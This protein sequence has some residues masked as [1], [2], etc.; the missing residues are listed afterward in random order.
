MAK[1]QPH[2]I[3]ILN[4]PVHS[5][6]SEEALAL[7]GNFIESGK[8]HQI[9]TVNAE[10][11]MTARQ[12]AKFMEA[13]Q[14]ADLALADSTSITWAARYAG[15]SLPE[16]ISGADFVV[17]LAK[18]AEQE[19]W[20]LYL[21]GGSENIAKKAAR[22]LKKQFPLLKIVGAEEG[23]TPNAGEKEQKKAILRVSKAKPDILLVALGAPKQDLFIYENKKEL[24]V[25]VMIGVGGTF[26]FL[27]GAVLRAPKI[28]RA[29]SLEWLWRLIMQPSR[30]RRIL[31]ATLIF[32]FN[33]IKEAKRTS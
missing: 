16:R 21:L 5:V 1:I 33:V 26:D 7:V 6:T 25:P 30:W 8:P 2:K 15:H 19:K 12:N 23:F 31:I 28:L 29:L 11:V 10:F 14:A 20:S 27:A 17:D 4:V 13:L 3:N 24:A 22:N 32:P 18:T 9:T